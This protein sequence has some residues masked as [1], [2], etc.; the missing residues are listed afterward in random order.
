MSDT[1]RI[2]SS[3]AFVSSPHILYSALLTAGTGTAS[4]EVQDSTDGT[5][6]TLFALTALG[7]VSVSWR[8][9]KGKRCGTGIYGVL[10]GTGASAAVEIE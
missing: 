6:G 10:I 9:G 4:L 5:S 3:T 1:K 7:N 8:L 2:T